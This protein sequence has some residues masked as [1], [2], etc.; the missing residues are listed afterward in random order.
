MV[1]NR[2]KH[3][4]WLR[5]KMYIERLEVT[6]TNGLV[7]KTLDS[8]PRGP[9]NKPTS[10]FKVDSADYQKS[11]RT[12]WYK[13]NCLLVAA[14]LPW[15]SW[16]SSIKMDHKVCFFPFPFISES[17]IKIKINLNFYFHTYL[18]C[19]KRFYEGVKGLHK[20]F[21]GTTKKIKIEVNFLSLSG[22]GKERVKFRN[23]W[24][25]LNIEKLNISRTDHDFFMK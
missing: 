10:G 18:W 4:K 25:G 1:P 24:N 5:F 15:G 20:T 3:H 7:V 2:A 23:W 19:L 17:L 14:F 6:R 22:I 16:T 9:M 11:L 8:L 12:Q 13:V 21:C